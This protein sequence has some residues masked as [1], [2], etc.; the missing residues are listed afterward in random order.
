M[1][2]WTLN[3]AECGTKFTHSVIEPRVAEDYY[4]PAKPEF[5]P[6][7]VESKCPGCGQKAIYQRSDL[8][9]QA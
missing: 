9:Y 1:P 5:A 8:R 7:G 6:G 3:C 4:L 2:S